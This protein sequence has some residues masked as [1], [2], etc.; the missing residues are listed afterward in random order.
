MAR[1]FTTRCVRRR[2]QVVLF[3]PAGVSPRALQR[4]EIHL[5]E[6]EALCLVDGKGF[7]QGE[8]AERMQVSRATVGRILRGVRRKLAR[9]LV[10]GQAIAIVEGRAPVK[11]RRAT[12]RPRPDEA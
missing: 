3:K 9:A 2:P 5:D 11:I 4:V 8:A 6:L 10:R 1:P 7:E 12:R